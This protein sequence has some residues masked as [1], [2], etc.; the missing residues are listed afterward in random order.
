VGDEMLGRAFAKYP[1]FQR[2]RVI[3]DK[4]T[5]K[6]KGFGFVSFKNPDDFLAAMREV[7]GMFCVPFYSSDK[8]P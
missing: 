4:R 1:S 2:S 5:G 7:N 6:T 8:S 3:R